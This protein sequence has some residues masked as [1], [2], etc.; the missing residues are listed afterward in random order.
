M[1]L[2][3]NGWSGRVIDSATTSRYIN[4]NKTIETA[5]QNAEIAAINR[6]N[7]QRASEQ[8]AAILS[9][10]R[11]GA[12]KTQAA[13]STLAA[14]LR[15][16]QAAT[17]SS[18][19]LAEFESERSQRRALS[20]RKADQSVGMVTAGFAASGVQSLGAASESVR[21][22]NLE[23]IVAESQFNQKKEGILQQGRSAIQNAYNTGI[24]AKGSRKAAGISAAASVAS[25]KVKT[26][27]KKTKV[28]TY[29]P[30]KPDVVWGKQG[31][32]PFFQ[33]GY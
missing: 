19:L 31:H 20:Q 33:K 16:S 24:Q 3:S 22:S 15:A 1:G 12:A 5:K 30:Y 32:L 25:S 10:A 14:S 23:R 28:N 26:A 6:R 9:R 17:N 13:A 4:K 29:N 27:Y 2:W 7:A 21:Q 8:R 11:T 18:R